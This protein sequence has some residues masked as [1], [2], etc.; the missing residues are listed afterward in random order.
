MIGIVIVM[1]VSIVVMYN[2]HANYMK[3]KKKIKELEEMLDEYY[4]EREQRLKDNGLI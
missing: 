2:Q 3:D 1:I 4:K